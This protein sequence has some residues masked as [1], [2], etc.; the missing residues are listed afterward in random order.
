MAVLA[1]LHAP[2][3]QSRWPIATR[4][5]AYRPGAAS[6]LAVVLMGLARLAW[7]VGAES[8]MKL[9]SETAYLSLL[10]CFFNLLPI[11]PLDGSHVLRN[12]TRMSYETYYSIARYGF[13][14]IIVVLQFPPV[15]ALLSG[16][17]V[18]TWEMIGGWFGLT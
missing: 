12:L 7:M 13:I 11:P 2:T 14:I 4:P 3:L 16:V 10:L 5:K 17:T 18:G 9:C 1:L 15:R 6:V 8:V